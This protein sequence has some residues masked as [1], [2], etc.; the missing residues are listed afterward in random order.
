[1]HA[2]FTEFLQTKGEARS[3]I[4][5]IPPAEL[6]ELL[7]EFILSV[8]TKEGQ[9][10]EP[11]SLRGMVASFERHLKRK[12]Y[13][14]SIINDLAFDRLRKTLHSKQKQLKKKGK[15]N[16]PHASVAL[17]EDEMKILYEKGLLGA[18]SPEAL[19]NALWLNN[20]LH[21]GLRGIEEHHDMRWG[22]VKLCKTDHGNEYLEFNEC[23]TKTRT[24]ADPCDVRPFAPKM[25]SAN[26]GEKDPVAVY[27]VFAGKSPEK[28][29]DPDA[30]FYT[31]V[32]NVKSKSTD[33]CWFKCNAVGINKLGSLMKEMS[34]KAGL[35]NDKLR[36]HSARKT[37][38]QSLSESDVPPTQIA[39]LSGHKSLKS[40]EN[41]S[42]LSTKQQ[43]HISNLL[44]NISSE[45]TS[46]TPFT[47][48]ATSTLTSTATSTS[49]EFRPD[50][51]SCHYSCPGQQSMALFPSAVIHGG[52]FSVT[53][54]TLN[55]SPPLL[56]PSEKRQW[57]RMRVSSDFVV[58]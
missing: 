49:G 32:N 37:M 30:P 44:A 46:I 56:P 28:M 36:N 40:N 12:S 5:E 19:L 16:K 42:H 26:G 17:T 8:R 9:D 45:C 39:Q 34:R 51:T 22:D 38:I 53:I 3:E 14:V 35:E 21:F 41:Y 7:S 57:K 29:N 18:S 52:Q 2:L 48:T 20:S 31:A 4:A 23:Q 50:G 10:Y 47:S 11:S 33:K 54:N 58:L 1:M 24:G 6:N 55:Q 43:M 15:G 25:C 13:P 27:K